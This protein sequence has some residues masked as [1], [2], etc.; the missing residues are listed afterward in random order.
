MNNLPPATVK[1]DGAFSLELAP[2]SF[3]LSARCEAKGS[4]MKAARMGDADILM[5]AS[6]A[7]HRRPALCR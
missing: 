3:E 1:A 7:R 6:M 4:Y 5:L 2:G